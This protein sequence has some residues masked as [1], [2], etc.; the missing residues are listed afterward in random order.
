MASLPPHLEITPIADCYLVKA[1][2]FID[3]RG[4]FEESYN[5][6]K[7][8]LNGSLPYIFMQDNLTFNNPNVLRGLHIQ[9][10]NPQG[11]LIRCLSGKIYDVCLDVR[12]GSPTFGKWF[13]AWLDETVGLYCPEGTAHGFYSPEKSVV[14]Y[15]CTGLYDK[16]SD[17][18]INPLDKAIGVDWPQGVEFLMSAKDKELPSLEEFVRRHYS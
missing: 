1:D 16:A 4:S 11:K 18:G 10:N 12:L 15:K 13:G 9:M 7:F 6:D 8:Y 2:K 3:E 5:A 17:T 14:Y